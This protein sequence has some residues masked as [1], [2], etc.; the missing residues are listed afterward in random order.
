MVKSKSNIC[1]S[2]KLLYVVHGEV[3]FFFFLLSQQ[4][5][6]KLIEAYLN[7]L[8]I[9]LKKTIRKPPIKWPHGHNRENMKLLLP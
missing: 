3:Y 2:S 1:P 8:L 7:Q 6:T 5:Y 4:Y 9:S